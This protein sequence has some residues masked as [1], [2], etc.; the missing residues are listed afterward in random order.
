M[1]VIKVRDPSSGDVKQFNIKGDTPTDT[2]KQKILS[3]LQQ[4][5]RLGQLKGL[6]QA[7]DSISNKDRENFD[8]KTGADSGLRALLSFGESAEDQ[9]AIL[10]KLV[11]AD[12]F[13]RDNEGRLALTLE[14][15]RKRGLDPIGKNLVI[16]DEGFSF[17]D[18][19]D[20]TGFVPE[21]VGAIGGTI[22]GL[23]LGL[24]GASAGAGAGAALGQT[25]E[26]GVESLLEYKN[27]VQRKLQKMLLQKQHLPLVLNLVVA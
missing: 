3:V 19:A 27:K 26:E 17:G 11:G 21:T 14:G 12:G 23:P 22:L 8:Y 15:Q 13:T 25:I 16:E 2:E 24:A 10:T 20:L 1:A 7:G 9:E 18:I 4:T 6:E 5:P